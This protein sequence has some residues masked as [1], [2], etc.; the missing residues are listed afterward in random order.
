MTVVEPPPD[1][2]VWGRSYSMRLKL[3][4]AE[5]KNKRHSVKCVSRSPRHVW[6][7][8]R[9][10]KNEAKVSLKGPR[11]P[12]VHQMRCGVFLGNEL[13]AWSKPLKV[14]VLESRRAR[15]GNVKLPDALTVGGHRPVYIR[16]TN[17]GNTTWRGGRVRLGL[18]SKGGWSPMRVPLPESE[19]VPPGGTA[20]FSFKLST[21]S[22]RGCT[23]SSGNY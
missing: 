1:S 15:I 6:G 19:V 9:V 22:P 23:S 20:E 4:L 17:T 10:F 5:N 12:G 18:Q 16:A 3:A 11:R 21:R 13:V 8:Q 14:R 2:V 7:E